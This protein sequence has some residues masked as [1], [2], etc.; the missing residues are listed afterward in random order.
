MLLIRPL[1]THA[2][3]S[4]LNQIR[5]K[6]TM[7]G[8]K[9]MYTAT[10]LKNYCIQKANW[11]LSLI[12]LSAYLFLSVSVSACLCLS[13]CLSLCLSVSVCIC[14]YLPVCLC[15]SV[16]L[17]TLII[18]TIIIILNVTQFKIVQLSCHNIFH[19]KGSS[20]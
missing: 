8:S 19:S 11:L 17:C 10:E 14:L 6:K 3:L 18:Q 4:T 13:V 20:H 7:K 9:K 12:C 15:L 2:H 16:C 1:R 5:V